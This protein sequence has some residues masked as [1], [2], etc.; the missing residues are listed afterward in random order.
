M[1]A[2]TAPPMLSYTSSLSTSCVVLHCVA[3][4]A[5]L[6][7]LKVAVGVGLVFYAA[8]AQRRDADVFL[9]IPAAA[10]DPLV[11][12][13]LGKERE[14][15]HTTPVKGGTAA[16]S[17]PP[18]PPGAGAS[19]GSS[20]FVPSSTPAPQWR[21]RLQREREHTVEVAA[22]TRVVPGRGPHL[23]PDGCSTPSR[24]TSICSAVS[25]CSTTSKRS[26][27]SQ[28]SLL[29]HRRGKPRTKDGA[30]EG[31]PSAVACNVTNNAASEPSPADAHVLMKNGIADL[32]ISC[33]SLSNDP[34]GSLGD[35]DVQNQPPSEPCEG[36]SALFNTP[37]LS[38]AR[39]N[40]QQQQQQQQQH[41]HNLHHPLPTHGG[42][43][44]ATG[45]KQTPLPAPRA[46]PALVWPAIPHG[47]MEEAASASASVAAS[48]GPQL[49]RSSSILLE[50]FGAYSVLGS[51]LGEGDVEVCTRSRRGSNASVRS[52]CS[53]RSTRSRGVLH[54]LTSS[55]SSEVEPCFCRAHVTRDARDQSQDM[56]VTNDAAERSREAIRSEDDTF[57]GKVGTSLEDEEQ[58]HIDDK[59]GDEEEEE[60]EVEDDE[61]HE[62]EGEGDEDCEEEEE[63]CSDAEDEALGGTPEQRAVRAVESWRRR[64]LAYEVS[65]SSA[66]EASRGLSRPR[67]HPHPRADEALD[68]ELESELEF[69]LS[70]T[71]AAGKGDRDL[72]EVQS[73]QRL[74]DRM[75]FME[76]LSS[77]ERYTV[78]KGRII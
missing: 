39:D 21:R 57:L 11:S 23:P 76:E 37:P 58:D 8:D 17:G 71:G 56:R 54:A 70:G 64:Q 7:A 69:E 68:A 47:L 10:V 9:R 27:Q 46:T 33:S 43:G 48:G 65:C 59:T 20:A 41:H 40:R 74:L 14:K 31:A 15:V 60:E 66:G 49:A 78:Y 5:G 30:A 6:V 4:F 2:A 52:R 61:Q 22:L 13:E 77:I 25:N 45:S 63:F 75:A 35:A 44:D 55:N 3:C 73:Q 34:L 26:Q 50:S 16:R 42:T 24:G 28:Q 72:L 67:P 62:Q 1:L 32:E 19:P 53:N 29:M 36:Q 51:V 18:P 12:K 38:P